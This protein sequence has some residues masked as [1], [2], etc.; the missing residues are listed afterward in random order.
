MTRPPALLAASTALAALALAGCGGSG[1]TSSSSGT[2]G[3]GAT[4][5][6]TAPT[7]PDVSASASS[8]ASGASSAATSAADRLQA[9]KDCLQKANLPMPTSTDAAGLLQEL[10][11]LIQNAQV[12][13][14]LQQ[15]NIPLT[16]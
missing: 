15:C 16:G 3:G 13:Q 8:L 1:S 7:S 9:V 2:V 4:V 6:A 12:R 5:S 10:P 14:A 11:K